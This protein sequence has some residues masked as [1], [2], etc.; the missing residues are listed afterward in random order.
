MP[1]IAR[2]LLASLPGL[3]WAVRGNNLS[4]NWGI[5]LN[6]DSKYLFLTCGTNTKGDNSIYTLIHQYQGKHSKDVVI[7]MKICWIS[8]VNTREGVYYVNS[9]NTLLK[10]PWTLFSQGVRLNYT[11][12]FSSPPKGYTTQYFTNKINIIVSIYL[13][14]K[15]PK[16]W[17]DSF[18]NVNKN[19]LRLLIIN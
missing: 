17:K 19:Y 2:L 16:E 11:P 10:I 6:S 7:K 4:T 3:P 14:H 13:Y 5:P 15:Q 9:H 12:W 18:N 8:L 1:K